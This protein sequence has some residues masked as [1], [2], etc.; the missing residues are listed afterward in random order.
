LKRVEKHVIKRE[1]K[2][3]QYCDEV[4][5][6]SRKLFNSAQYVQRQSYFY[7]HGFFSQPKLDKLFQ[8]DENYK[9][10]PAKVAQLVLQQCA[11]AWTNYIKAIAAY[12]QDPSKF[13]GKPK[14]PGYVKDRNLVKFNIQAVGLREFK[15]GNIVPSMSPIQLPVKQGLKFEDLCEVRIV[16]KTGCYVIEVVYEDLDNSTFSCSLNPQL[17]AAIDIGLDNLATI[18]F[19]DP[20]IGPIAVN[21]K[22]L[23]SANQFYNKQVAKFRG[24]IKHGTSRRIQDII[25]NRNNFVDDYLHQC[26]RIIVKE[27]LALGVTSVAIGKNDQWKT[28]IKLGKRTNQ[29]LVQI[30]HARFIEILTYK[31]EAV[32]IKVVVGKESYTSRASFLDWDNIPT[33]TPGNKE[34]PSFSGRRVERSWYVAHDGSKIH[35]DVNGAFNIGRKVIPTAFDR[36]KSIVQRDRGCLV[37]HPRRITPVFKRAHAKTGV[38]QSRV[39]WSVYI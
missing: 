35:A 16:P 24:F 15:K 27:F 18:V 20:T 1:H 28:N 11:D 22:P 31:L 34:K 5:N 6:S 23:K 25:R 26:T 8:Q 21:G 29:K 36:L 13:T 33:Y 9:A 2:W 32:G 4:T 3:F 7:E 39:K 30:P 38:A 12:S 17:A 19:S 37:V 10:L 14:I